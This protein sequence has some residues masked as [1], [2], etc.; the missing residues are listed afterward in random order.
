MK[1][2]VISFHRRNNWQLWAFNSQLKDVS[3]TMDYFYDNYFRQLA[4]RTISGG[5]FSGG[6]RLILDW[7][8]LRWLG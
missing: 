5:I 1:V 7:M 3:S 4:L 8:Q 2:F 6:T